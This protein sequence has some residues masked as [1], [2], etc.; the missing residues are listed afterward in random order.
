ME[1]TETLTDAGNRPAA[2]S[3]AVHN[4]DGGT[5]AARR[6][7]RRKT[8]TPLDRILETFKSELETLPD[9]KRRIGIH[10]DDFWSGYMNVYTPD[11]K[12]EK[13]ITEIFGQLI[14]GVKNRPSYLKE[15]DRKR[16]HHPN[17]FQ[18]E[19]MVGAMLYVDL[20]CQNIRG[21]RD[22]I[23][24]LKELGINMV[25]LMPV[26]KPRDGL[27]DGG[28]AVEDFRQVDPKL[29]TIDELKKI[30]RELHD[31][32]ISL[33]LDFVMNHT[34]REHR[35]AQ[36]ALSG[37]KKYQ[38]YYVMFDRR[39]EV[40]EYEDHLIEVFPDFAPG[41]FTY[42]PQIDKW[43]W[44]TFYEFQWD[45]N[46]SNPDV[47]QAM[48]DEMLF[49]ANA[50][51]DVLR[52]DAVPYIWKRKGTVCQNE[53][54]VHEIVRAYRALF[55]MA[56][57]SVLFKAEAI[58]GPEQIVKYLGVG[59][60]EGKE[61]DLAYNAT[62]MCHLWHALA[63]ENTHLIR[64][65]LDSL[66]IA[67][68]EAS[69]INYIRCHDDIGWGIGDDHA[70]AVQQNGYHTR[71]FCTDFYS[72]EIKGSY[73]LGYPFQRDYWTGE[74]RISGTAAALSG[75]Q[76]SQINAD[77]IGED[78]AIRRLLLL[79]NVISSWNGIPLIYMGDEVGQLNNYQYL[80][81][82]NKMR[83]NRWVH[84]P[85][86]PWEKAML[87]NVPGTVEYRLFNGI[88]NLM[89]ARKRSNMLDARSTDRVILID[90]DAVF[91]FER[92]FAGDKMLMLSN[93]SKSSTHIPLELL[94][95]EWRS[96]W[97]HDMV[98][99]E[100]L[101][102]TTGEVLLEPYGFFWLKKAGK[103]VE[104]EV[105]P[106]IISVIAET[107]P[108]EEIFLV[109]NIA[110]LGSWNPENAAGPMNPYAY[111]TWEIELDLPSDTFFEFQ[112]VKK[113]DGKL[114]EWSVNKFWMESGKEIFFY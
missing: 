80:S 111:P 61:C 14:R 2:E 28:Y 29:G 30:T 104:S 35:W 113:R 57:P 54:E 45:L 40:N 108:G 66:P 43:V 72:G 32:G 5:S 105:A 44:T 68:K 112:W 70:A 94:P 16:E 76:K 18:T 101:H 9:L 59:G 11:R 55:R 7:G 42:Y 99:N 78:D 67:P 106:T 46:Y 89:K 21:L 102:F 58:V 73:S 36:A 51:V 47:F 39:E 87:R 71:M 98:R 69:W 90:R 91:A 92:K 41:S 15:L 103:P 10:F 34:A 86:M 74:A 17:W 31:E 114:L 20:F 84:R 79:Y 3:D 19:Q 25:H 75:L 6:Q 53:P 93:F 27:N 100:T 107:N 49:L 48:L 22:R 83:D 62:L 77:E 85:A 63:C 56:A 38:K 110:E 12:G 109:G 1:K 60:A 65:T 23:D 96:E 26:L 64:T 88:R 13:R 81:D 4:D 82:M 37:Q 95:E 52:L 24:Y 50:G 97:Y 33:V 8:K